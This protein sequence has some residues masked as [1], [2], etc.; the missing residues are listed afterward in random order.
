MKKVNPVFL[1]MLA[2]VITGIMG[3]RAYSRS[4]EPVPDTR[5]TSL[6][7]AFGGEDLDVPYVP[8]PEEVVAKMLDMAQVNDKDLLYDLGCGDGRIVVMAA[9]K[10]GARA[11][12]FDLNPERLSESNQNARIAGVTDRVRFVKQ[13]LFTTDLSKATV[14][15]MY[16]L[17]S[18]NLK[19]R[20]KLFAQLRPGTRIVSH[21]FDMGDWEPDQSADINGHQVYYW[22][23]PANAS[24]IWEWSVPSRNGSR[25]CSMKMRQRYQ[26]A[27]GVLDDQNLIRN[28]RITGANIRFTADTTVNG[29]VMP[30]EYEGS[31]SGN[32]IKGVIRPADGSAVRPMAWKAHRKAAT[33]V[34]ICDGAGPG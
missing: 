29:R 19:L 13:D 33:A 23:I 24:G 30:M 14:V 34:S 21:D 20:P 9:Q 6:T 22:V 8:T 28:V 10:K 1:V 32:T 3:D 17:P 7:E 25:Q 26:K 5:Q 11:I 12:G 18:V 4:S 16:L 27:D 2:L 15:S 31:V